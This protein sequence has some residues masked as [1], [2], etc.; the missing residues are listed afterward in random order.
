M[1]LIVRKNRARSFIQ[2][3]VFSIVPPLR[4]IKERVKLLENL[5]MEKDRSINFLI[6]EQDVTELDTN[7]GLNRKVLQ[8]DTSAPAALDFAGF[9]NSKTVNV[10][11]LPI[12]EKIATVIS[13]ELNLDE[14]VN[15]AAEGMWK[16]FISNHTEILSLLRSDHQKAADYLEQMYTTALTHGFQQGEYIYN[17][18]C[19][20]QSWRDHCARF[21]MDKLCGLAEALGSVPVENPEQGDWGTLMACDPNT[22]LTLIE[23]SLNFEIRAPRFQAGV[24]GLH[25]TRGVFTEREFFS[26]LI[27]KTISELVADKNTPI[28]EIGGG[29][30]S[31]AY[32]C[33]QFGFRNI[34]VIDL[35]TVNIAQAY[36]LHRNLPECELYLSG[37][38]KVFDKVPGIRVLS[39]RYL[40]LAP[41]HHFGLV[42]NVDSFPELSH[43][44]VQGYLRQIQQKTQ[45]FLSINQ[46]SAAC[47]EGVTQ[48]IVHEQI[49]LVGGFRRRSRHPFWLRKGYVEEIYEIE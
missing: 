1:S 33:W 31:L 3:L 35:P 47:T 7:H 18:L 5:I 19:N 14:S 25:T 27:A 29:G 21:Q 32:Y 37:D 38:G 39:T 45:L 42:V 10:E 28:C 44:I 8:H 30:G 2:V 24:Y 17:K 36:W 26:I 9:D 34:T 46:E 16:T 48:L 20:H 13:E 4:R 6:K 11:P 15:I 23:K 43:Q 12:I 40:E 49:K 22:L 41:R